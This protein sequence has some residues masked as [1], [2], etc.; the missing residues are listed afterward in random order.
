MQGNTT[1][2]KNWR[3]IILIGLYKGAEVGKGRAKAEAEFLRLRFK[4]HYLNWMQDVEVAMGFYLIYMM[5][6]LPEKWLKTTI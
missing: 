3:K 1:C 6:D 4:H 2:W 5:E